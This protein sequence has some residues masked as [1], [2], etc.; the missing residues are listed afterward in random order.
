MINLLRKLTLHLIWYITQRE[1]HEVFRDPSSLYEDPEGQVWIQNLQSDTKYGFRIRAFNEFGPGPYV[2][3]YFSALPSTP[4][5]P[6]LIKAGSTELHLKWLFNEYRKNWLQELKAIFEQLEC[7]GSG[8]ILREEV[9][10]CLFNCY[11]LFCVI[12]FVFYLFFHSFSSLWHQITGVFYIFLRP[13]LYL[14]NASIP[15]PFP[16]RCLIALN[17]MIIK[18]YLGKHS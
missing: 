16:L 15:Q 8:N 5:P 11:T 13:D 10:S 4:Q 2:H 6:V 1:F 12:S 17:Q 14:L 7:D 3:K 9:C 18:Q